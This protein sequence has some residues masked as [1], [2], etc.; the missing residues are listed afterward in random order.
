MKMASPALIAETCGKNLKREITL[1]KIP[2]KLSDEVFAVYHE[3]DGDH[4]KPYSYFIGCKVSSETKLPEG[5][6]SLIIPEGLYQ[7]ITAKGKI[8][9]CII[10]AWKEIWSCPGYYQVLPGRL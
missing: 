10:N 5:M 4:T 9:G 6:D 8:P 7:Q 2:N 3:Y 1:N